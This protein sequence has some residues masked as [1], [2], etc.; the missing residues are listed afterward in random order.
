MNLWLVVIVA[1]VLT[2]LIRLSFIS[3]P[4]NWE[5][6]HWAQR[7][8]SFV[9]PAVMTAIVFPE[10]LVRDGHLAANLDNN[11]LIAGAIAIMVAWQFKRIMPTIVAGMAALWL[12]QHFWI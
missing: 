3:L 12:L 11:R 6:P 9:P 1:G 4:A 7:A 2:F 10:L 5:M 8:L